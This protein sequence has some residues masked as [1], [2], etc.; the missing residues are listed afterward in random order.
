[1]AFPAKRARPYARSLLAIESRIVVATSR[2]R[3]TSN[4]FD[5]VKGSAAGSRRTQFNWRRPKARMITRRVRRARYRGWTNHNVYPIKLPALVPTKERAAQHRS[6]AR[7][8]NETSVLMASGMPLS[9]RSRRMQLIGVSRLKFW[10]TN[11]ASHSQVT[12]ERS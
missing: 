4:L 6:E 10:R 5:D 7:S 9:A 12:L 1:M 11:H 8:M 2:L 3:L